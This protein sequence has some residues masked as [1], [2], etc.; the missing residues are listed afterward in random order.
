MNDQP[1]AE[2]YNPWTVGN[3]VFGHLVDEGL[4]PTLGSVSPGDPAAELLRALGIRPS[5]EGDSR[6]GGATREKLAELRATMED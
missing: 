4:H 3:L 6:I 5:L 2:T 1:P